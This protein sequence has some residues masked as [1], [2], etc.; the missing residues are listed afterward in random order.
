[1]VNIYIEIIQFLWEILIEIFFNTDNFQLISNFLEKKTA[2]P[3]LNNYR[4][5]V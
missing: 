5:V 3:K 4:L 2:K 1:M